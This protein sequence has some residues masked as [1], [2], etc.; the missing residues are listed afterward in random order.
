MDDER[1]GGRDALSVP[2]LAICFLCRC[3]DALEQRFEDMH[4][5]DVIDIGQ[6]I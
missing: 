5:A 3:I 4:A 2:V 1:E 6:A